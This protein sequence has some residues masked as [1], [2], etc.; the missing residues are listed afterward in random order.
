MSAATATQPPT[1]GH[2]TIAAKHAT[3]DWLG[4]VAWELAVLHNDEPCIKKL[5]DTLAETFPARE[6]AAILRDTGE[7]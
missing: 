3:R 6:F 5:L 4:R 2:T 1:T 7:F